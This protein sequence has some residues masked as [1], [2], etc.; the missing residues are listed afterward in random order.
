MASSR[1]DFEALVSNLKNR[2]PQRKPIVK[3]K[4]SPTTSF[5]PSKVNFIESDSEEDEDIDEEQL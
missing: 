2:S 1:T 5:V 4:T 3:V